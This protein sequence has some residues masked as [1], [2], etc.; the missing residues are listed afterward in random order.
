VLAASAFLYGLS[1]AEL[2]PEELDAVDA[3]YPVTV[4]ARATVGE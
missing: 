2:T 1:A 4:A 3:C